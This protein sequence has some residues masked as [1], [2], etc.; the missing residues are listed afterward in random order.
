MNTTGEF[1]FCWVGLKP[2]TGGAQAGVGDGVGAGDAVGTGDADGFDDADGSGLGV[3][4]GVGLGV[5]AA[6][7]SG[8]GGMTT[9]SASA[10]ASNETSGPP[11][12]TQMSGVST[13]K[14]PVTVTRT[15]V[16]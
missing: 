2:T 13:W 11:V 6:V 1:L 9:T 10:V 16:P 12:K 5:G 15:V 4:V 14:W 8:A 3:G 7:A